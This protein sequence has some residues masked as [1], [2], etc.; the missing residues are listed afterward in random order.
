[1][2]REFVEYATNVVE[3]DSGE[4]STRKGRDNDVVL[5]EALE[6]FKK[7]EEFNVM[8]S[9]H[10]RR[11]RIKAHLSGTKVMEWTGLNGRSI[12]KIIEVMR[13]RFSDNELLAFTEESLKE[14]VLAVQKE[15]GYTQGE[16][17]ALPPVTVE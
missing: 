11:K 9:V 10:G 4:L 15:L 8:A 5:Q 12:G 3:Q 17:T 14:T 6:Y 13:S 1:M 7:R 16:G 2:Y